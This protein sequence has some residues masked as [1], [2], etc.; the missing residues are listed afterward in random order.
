MTTSDIIEVL[1]I[2]TSTIIGLISIYYSNKAIKIASNANK[3]TAEITAETNRPVVV[4]YL[5]TVEI[6]SFHK[7]MVIKNFGNTPATILDLKFMQSIDEY[8]FNMS[9]LIGYT[10]A[11]SQKFM[12]VIDN[13][14]KGTVIINIIYQTVTGQN[15]DEVYQVKLNATEKLFWIGSNDQD[16]QLKFM[17][18]AAEAFI[19]VLK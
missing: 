16:K 5:E 2:I 6:E 8:D 4:A 3:L 10:I 1:S 15:F 17:K 13:D 18:N 19:K 14:L 11:P 7:Y 12:H 9:S